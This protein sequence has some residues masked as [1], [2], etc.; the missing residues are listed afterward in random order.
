MIPLYYY[1]MVQGKNAYIYIYIYLSVYTYTH[2][3][4]HTYTYV[5][6]NI[7]IEM[8]KKTEQNITNYW[9]LGVLGNNGV[10]FLQ[11]CNYA[12]MLHE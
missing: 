9:I 5:N 12:K 2:I 4:T 3:Y 1:L 10:T 11:V 6:V 7:Y 8:T